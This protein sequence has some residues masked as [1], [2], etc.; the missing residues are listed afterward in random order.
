[1][2]RVHISVE[3]TFGKLPRPK[4]KFHDPCQMQEIDILFCIPEGQEMPSFLEIFQDRANWGGYDWTAHI[5]AVH[6]QIS[7]PIY[8]HLFCMHFAMKPIMQYC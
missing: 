4:Q 3:W 8:C 2:S 6:Y 5:H 1:M 7:C